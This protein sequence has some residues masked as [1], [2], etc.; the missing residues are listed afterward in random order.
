MIDD[1]LEQYALYETDVFIHN[2]AVDRYE[3][4]VEEY[5]AAV[6]QFNEE[7]SI[8]YNQYLNHVITYE[9]YL[10]WYNRD[11]LDAWKSRL[12][13]ERMRLNSELGPLNQRLAT[14]TSSEGRS[15]AVYSYWQPPEGVVNTIEYMW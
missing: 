15:W 4:E 7:N 3:A 10:D 11:Q 8:K 6:N 2:Q 5:T 12:D 9:E 1:F 14:L 13:S